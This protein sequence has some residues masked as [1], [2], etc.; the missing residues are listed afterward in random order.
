MHDEIY[1]ILVNLHRFPFVCSTNIA[2]AMALS[3]LPRDNENGL[4]IPRANQACVA[5]RKQKR[6]CTKELPTCELCTRMGRSCD[7]ADSQPAPTAEDLVSLQIR[8]IELENKLNN[9][10]ALSPASSAE[11]EM[12]SVPSARIAPWT[13]SPANTFRT[14]L[15]LDLDVFKWKSMQNPKPNVE[16]PMVSPCTF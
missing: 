9:R 10:Q 13:P 6:K 14:P 4:M 8:L 1:A 2:P 12:V 3:L 5:C 7:Y 16:I 15:F 11:K